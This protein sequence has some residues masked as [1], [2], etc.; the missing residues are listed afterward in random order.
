M[1]SFKNIMTWEDSRGLSKK[2]F[3]FDIL[4]SASINFWDLL[5]PLLLISFYSK[6]MTKQ[7][8]IKT[9]FHPLS[10]SPSSALS[11]SLSLSPPSLSCAIKRKRFFIRCVKD[12][13]LVPLFFL[14]AMK[15]KSSRS[16]RARLGVR[17]CDEREIVPRKNVRS[18]ERALLASHPLS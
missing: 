13:F 17:A 2:W 9:N 16:A 18:F 3:I 15:W 4:S 8:N 12:S 6:K 5:A 14:A 11:P 10:L 7:S 1:K